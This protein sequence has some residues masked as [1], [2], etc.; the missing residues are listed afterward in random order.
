M[1]IVYVK[2]I[3]RENTRKHERI[4]Y[5]FRPLIEKIIMPEFTFLDIEASFYEKLKENLE[6]LL[7]FRQVGVL[8]MIC[9]GD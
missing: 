8:N 4:R 6:S 9:F 3:A 1:S 7:V 2:F 5:I